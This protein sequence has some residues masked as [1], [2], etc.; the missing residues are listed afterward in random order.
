VFLLRRLIDD[1]IIGEGRKEGKG[2]DSMYNTYYRKE[3]KSL[4]MTDPLY[5][6]LL[7]SW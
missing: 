7:P 6:V 1:K 5:M 3:G 4:Y 2:K